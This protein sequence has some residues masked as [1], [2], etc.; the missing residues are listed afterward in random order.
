MTL[1]SFFIC[2]TTLCAVILCRYPLQTAESPFPIYLDPSTPMPSNVAGK[3]RRVSVEQTRRI[4]DF[5]FRRKR[6]VNNGSAGDSA[7]WDGVAILPENLMTTGSNSCNHFGP[8]DYFSNWASR[9]PSK[10]WIGVHHHT[11]Y[12]Q[13][14]NKDVQFFNSRLLGVP[15]FPLKGF[16]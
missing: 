7:R 8:G 12:V 13:G 16:R 1:T 6:N 5:P 15:D 14:L 2:R 10:G 4:L 3:H 11:R 9:N